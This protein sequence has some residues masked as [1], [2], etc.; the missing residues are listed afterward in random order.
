MKFALAGVWL[1]LAILLRERRFFAYAG[2]IV[3]MAHLGALVCG[4]LYQAMEK[5]S[6]TPGV[7]IAGF[8]VGIAL[9]V[10]AGALIGGIAS[11]SAAVYW[12]MQAIAVGFLMFLPLFRV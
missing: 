11:R 5:P 8:L 6:A 3:A 9:G 12:A 4:R 7:S 2:S 10:L 1:A